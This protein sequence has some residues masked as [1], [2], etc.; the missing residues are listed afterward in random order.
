MNFKGITRYYWAVLKR[1]PRSQLGLFAAYGTAEIIAAAAIPLTFKYIIDYVSV[2]T[3]GVS[4]HPLGLVLTLA[5]LF[6]VMNIGF[7]VGDYLM[8]WSQS[9]ILRDLSDLTLEKLQNHSFGFFANTFAGSLIAK[10]RR[11]VSAF[12]TLHDQI[13]FSLWFG[14]LSLLSSTVV[15]WFQSPVLGALFLLWLVL[16][17]AMVSVL[18]RYQIPKGMAH[19]EADSATTAHYSDIISNAFTVKTFGSR[20]IEEAQFRDTTAHQEQK[21]RAA[22]MQHSFWGG[23]WQGSNIGFFTVLF[24]SVAI[25]LWGYGTVSTGTI[26]LM[27]MYTLT[28][29]NVVW[30]ISKNIIRA[31]EALTDAHEMVE[32]LDAP[33]TVA[34]P[35][36]PEPISMHDGGIVFQNVSFSYD[37]V[38]HVFKDL[39]LSITPGEHVAL[40]GHSGAGKTT[41]TKILLRFQD[42]AS[43]TVTIDG[44]D[45]THVRQDEL[46]RRIAYVPQ[47]PILFHRSL[48]AN[49]AYG[50]PEASFDEVVAAAEK[51]HAHEFI[52]QLPHGY[53]TLV[54]ERGIKLSGGE[55]QRVAIARA[56]LKDAP[57]VIFDE[58]T[59]ALDSISEGKIQDALRELTKGRTT[60][61]IAHRLSTIQHVDRIIVF[62]GGK[63]TEEGTHAALLRKRGVY[64]ELWH[65]QVG[66][67]IGE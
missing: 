11:F 40:V 51:A 25:W 6:F 39:N 31:F 3:P 52:S 65:S 38:Q 62:S 7:R 8:I 35:F 2:S 63:I 21:R 58:A 1:Y 61:V 36:A 42:V 33:V 30:N 55:R 56:I 29:F 53:D 22:W 43:G 60:I 28:S 46:R 20:T 59:S 15:L 47:E 64:A 45:I 18:V 9:Q 23:L 54:G 4:P 5:A 32:I 24:V 10:T 49:I 26:V 12:E 48:R 17:I 27:Q 14:V 13:V 19:A 41:I 34:D 37:E 50:R 67:F 66:G 44:Q 57:V 16:Y